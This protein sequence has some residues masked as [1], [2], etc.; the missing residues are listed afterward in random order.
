MRWIQRFRIMRTMQMKVMLST[1]LVGT[2]AVGIIAGTFLHRMPDML[3]ARTSEATLAKLENIGG[4]IDARLKNVVT[5]LNSLASNT[6]VNAA[7]QGDARQYTNAEATLI[8]TLM[9]TGIS[10]MDNLV[11]SIVMY[12]YGGKFY[13]GGNGSFL[14]V[15][16][17][18]RMLSDP[19]WATLTNWKL[20]LERNP[21]SGSSFRYV[22]TLYYP[23]RDNTR[24][25][26]IG[27]ISASLLPGKL[28]AA[29]AAEN[30]NITVV[31]DAMYIVYHSDQSRIG[32]PYE[33]VPPNLL[34]QQEGTFSYELDGETYFM[35]Y[36]TVSLTGWKIIEKIPQSIVMADVKEFEKNF[37]LVL[38]GTVV[39]LV[40]LSYFISRGISRSVVMLNTAMDRVRQGDYSAH[41]EI[42]GNDEVAQLG[43]TFNKMTARISRLIDEIYETEEKKHQSDMLALQAQINPHFLYNTLNSI[44]WM[45][46]LHGFDNISKMVNAL[47]QILRYSLNSTQ[48]DTSVG[49]EVEML[50][51]YLFIQNVRYNNGVS[52]SSTIEP[53]AAECAIPRLLLQPLVENA[54]SH[55]LRPKGGTGR[56]TVWCRCYTDLLLIDVTDDGVG[57][58]DPVPE[59]EPYDVLIEKR[60][61]GERPGTGV[62]LENT[63]NRIKVH[64]G[65]QYGLLVRSC[66]GEGSTVRVVLPLRRHTAKEDADAEGYDRG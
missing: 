63:N 64:F 18:K 46:V 16:S 34:A 35:V 50:H 45:A 36:T 9:K 59:F 33:D 4:N 24:L 2:I 44:H 37:L 21:N 19:E 26:P 51:P 49:Q 22:I 20:V 62:G 48:F 13:A 31:D 3:F 52:F 25:E 53:G 15:D 47:V 43:Q 27:I 57:F 66:A 7:L 38:L 10:T 6:A 14:Y 42:V 1:V 40:V 8:S 61:T 60:N 23:L 65:D 55:G 29:A 54:I 39:F 11:D 17:L 56:V 58:S 30:R 28:M 32:M 41:V 5:Y 12:T